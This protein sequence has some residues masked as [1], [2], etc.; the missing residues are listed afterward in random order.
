MDMGGFRAGTAMTAVQRQ[1]LGGKMTKPTAEEMEAVGLLKPGMWHKSGVGVFVDKGGLEGEDILKDPEKGILEWANKILLPALAA[2]HITSNVDVQ[3]EL[4][5]LFG[6]ETARRMMGLFIQN[7]SQIGRDAKLYENALPDAYG[8]LVKGDLGANV[9]NLKDAVTSFLQAFG[10]PM[11]PIAINALHSLADGINSVAGMALAHQ[12]AMKIVG[13]SLVGLS[14]GLITLGGAAV[15]G[16][17]L[18]IV[19]PVGAAIL[20][21]GGAITAIGAM[22][23]ESASK[24]LSVFWDGI[25]IV[26]Q[27]PRGSRGRLRPGRGGV[28]KAFASLPGLVTD[29]I[30]A[31]PGRVSDAMGKSDDIGAALSGLRDSITRPFF[32]LH[33][34]TKAAVDGFNDSL[35]K[36]G[37]SISV[38]MNG[39]VSQFIAGI[40]SIPGK[41]AGAIGAM[42]SGIANE[43]AA[44][45]GRLGSSLFH[46]PG[47]KDFGFPS[48]P[49]ALPGLAPSSSLPTV[50]YPP[51]HAAN[52][53]R[54]S[55][56][57]PESLKSEQDRETSRGKAYSQPI[58]IKTAL[59]LDGRLLAETI[60][61]EL[62]QLSTFPRQAPYGDSYVGWAAPDYNFSTG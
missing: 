54:D 25:K 26:A 35:A 19:G 14:A 36:F 4:Y 29:A 18:A 15:V 20:G 40:E 38:A 10:A 44:T 7:Q 12:D 6:T 55:G 48:A 1:L 58:H 50:I 17:A 9:T 31:I 3:Q 2:R 13:E 59:Y 24:G 45:L 32:E 60:S 46:F 8:N 52:A 34:K 56:Y 41:L 16:A 37:A 47:L 30:A 57:T 21:L 11:V 43:I 61:S 62:A 23:W 39:I 33:D 28:A 27:R 53:L 49:Y 51:G 22:N 5:R 42:A